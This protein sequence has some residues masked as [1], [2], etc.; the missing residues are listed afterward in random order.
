MIQKCGLL[1]QK[2]NQNW[3]KT[4]QGVG[5][6]T[7]EN[8]NNSSP[9]AS[10]S[11]RSFEIKGNRNL[12]ATCRYTKYPSRDVKLPIP[13]SINY[14]FIFIISVFFVFTLPLFS[15]KAPIPDFKHPQKERTE[16]NP[17]F[18]FRGSRIRVLP[19]SHLHP[20]WHVRRL[21]VRLTTQHPAKRN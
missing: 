7:S 12:T 13:Q 10:P 11:K 2:G 19:K 17:R 21:H 20:T 15:S 5:K 14:R 4:E 9:F 8:R 6:E 3:E 18:K 1:N 16:N